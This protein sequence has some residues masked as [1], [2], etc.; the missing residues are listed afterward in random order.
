LKEW[1]ERQHSLPTSQKKNEKAKEM[2]QPSVEAILKMMEEG[3]EEGRT[4]M[5]KRGNLH[6][7]NKEEE[8]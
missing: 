5:R 3:L 8:L 4:S 1:K 6:S 2:K 7:E